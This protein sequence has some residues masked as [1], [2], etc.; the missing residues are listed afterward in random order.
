MR[1]LN[2]RQNGSTDNLSISQQERTF[3]PGNSWQ[4]CVGHRIRCGRICDGDLLPSR[5]SLEG[6]ERRAA[7]RPPSRC[8][9]QCN[10]PSLYSNPVCV[11]AR[12]RKVYV[13]FTC[14]SLPTPDKILGIGR[15]ALTLASLSALQMRNDK[16]ES[17]GETNYS[18]SGSLHMPMVGKVL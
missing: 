14:D 12:T 6:S 10:S 2:V 13:H 15:Q 4:T 9:R 7:F 8:C 3:S 16:S 5:F 18:D 1:R 11:N 17:I